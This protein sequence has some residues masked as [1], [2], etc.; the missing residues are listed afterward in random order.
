MRDVRKFSKPCDLVLDGMGFLRRFL[1]HRDAYCRITIVDSKDVR[2]T[3]I[4]W[5]SLWKGM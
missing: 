2:R 3:V 5:N 1:K 4:A